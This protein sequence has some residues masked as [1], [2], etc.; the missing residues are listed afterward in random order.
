MKYIKAGEVV[1]EKLTTP[2]D[3]QWKTLDRLILDLRIRKPRSSETCSDFVTDLSDYPL[4]EEIVA[5]V[6]SRSVD[7]LFEVLPKLEPQSIIQLVG[8]EGRNAYA[9]FAFY[10]VGAFLKKYPFSGKMTKQK[11]IASFIANEKVCATYNRTNYKALLA[12][13]SRHPDFLGVVEEI[14]H[15]IVQLIGAKPCSERIF[16]RA[17]HGPGVAF[18]DLYKDGECT[19]YFKWSRL[20]YSVTEA[21]RPHAQAVIESDP[22]WI[23]ALLDW[24]RESCGIEQ[25]RPINLDDFWSKV[26]RLVDGSRITTVPKT[27][28]TD[29][30]IAIEPLLNV[31]LQLG[32]DRELKLRLK[33][34]WGYNLNSQEK[35][36]L[37]AKKA[38]VSNDLATIDLSAASDLISLRICAIL[39][40]EL[41]FNLLYEL[42]SPKGC[43][44]GVWRPYEKISSMGNGY[45]FALESLIFAALVRCAIRRTGSERESAVFGDDLIVPT[46]AVNYLYTLLELCGFRINKEKSF[47]SGPFRESCGVDRFLGYNVR[48]VFLKRRLDSIPAIFY[49]HNRLT[50]LQEDA[51]WTWALDFSNTLAYLRKQIPSGIRS[52]FYG[53]RTENLDTHLFSTSPLRKNPRGQRVYWALKPVARCFNRGTLFFFRKLMA[54]LSGHSYKNRWDLESG[55]PSTGNAFD[56]TKRGRVLLKSTRVDLP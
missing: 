27:A 43:L 20:P 5:C 45:T 17:Q 34:R 40:P 44:E 23:G 1:S 13:S 52:Q 12:M 49:L 4:S 16:V 7:K 8:S 15:D 55:G 39:L 24:Y 32:V 50:E 30:T 35:N 38:A 36:Q 54:S 25:W 9:F 56:V 11:A 47:T 31:Y 22:R 10:Q 21:A 51:D 18:G 26:F 46:T 29:R 6:R 48:P 28:K 14:R 41:W 2:R 42:R 33:S 53:P 19:A 3:I 37:L